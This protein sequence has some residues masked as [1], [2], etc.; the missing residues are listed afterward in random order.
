M[1]FQRFFSWT[2]LFGGGGP[3]K[4][5]FYCT[6][7]LF[8]VL[9][10][11]KET[12]THNDILWRVTSTCLGFNRP[13]CVW[14]STC[15][16]FDRPATC[17][18]K[19]VGRAKCRPA[20][21]QRSHLPRGHHDMPTTAKN[22]E[23]LWKCFVVADGQG[24]GKGVFLNG[25]FRQVSVS[26]FYDVKAKFSTGQIR[27]RPPHSPNLARLTNIICSNRPLSVSVRTELCQSVDAA[28]APHDVFSDHE[29]SGAIPTSH[30]REDMWS[31]SAEG[32]EV[33]GALARSIFGKG[34]CP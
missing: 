30:M 1:R 9:D 25:V 26:G 27:H 34:T 16:Q 14:G 31:S 4:H 19:P 10:H 3:C 22:P 6:C 20:S 17:L 15:T 32:R 13:R 18:T 28:V 11:E 12:H 33:R 2:E 21:D 8:G 5:R 24:H 7:Y 29:Y 23:N